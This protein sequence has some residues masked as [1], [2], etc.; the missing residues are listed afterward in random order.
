MEKKQQ[1]NSNKASH[2][3]RYLGSL[4][5]LSSS[6]QHFMESLDSFL[7]IPLVFLECRFL[8]PEINTVLNSTRLSSV[9]KAF[10]L[11][12]RLQDKISD[13]SQLPR[14][15]FH[16]RYLRVIFHHE[17]QLFDQAN[18]GVFLFFSLKPVKNRLDFLDYLLDE[19]RTLVFSLAL[20]FV[21]YYVQSRV[22]VFE[23]CQLL[24]LVFL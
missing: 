13:K 6:I 17:Y 15:N 18:F 4:S 3:L 9:L 5:N 24:V 7:L 11:L 1:I 22:Q 12:F 8:P 19:L 21:L 23:F 10:N 16:L 20:E 2:T 14:S